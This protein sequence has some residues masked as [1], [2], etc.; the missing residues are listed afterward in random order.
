ML[1]NKPY[2]VKTISDAS[3]QSE[4]IS[5]MVSVVIPVHN[6][7]SKLPMC[8]QA[9][10]QSEYSNYQI[11]VVDDGS[12][13][14]TIDVAKQYPCT[15]V[16]LQQN[17]GPS[18]ARNVGVEHAK[19]E[20]VLFIDDDVLVQPNTISN[21][22][23]IFRENQDIAAMVGNLTKK[24]GFKN[25]FSQFKNLHHRYHLCLFPNYI[26][27][28]FTSITA[29]KREIFL[30]ANGFNEK[31]NT[32][33][34]EDVEFGQRLSDQGFKILHVKNLNVM[35]F[36]HYSLETY[37]KN[38]LNRSYCHFK[39]FLINHGMKRMKNDKKVVYFPI[40]TIISFLIGPLIFLSIPFLYM[41]GDFRGLLGIVF[42]LLMF[43]YLNIGFLNYLLKNK[44][45]FF[46]FRAYMVVLL[47]S[48]IICIGSSFVLVD[49][50]LGKEHKWKII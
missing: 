13:D 32:P 21:I 45:P 5:S 30:Q 35:H 6:G 40:S 12:S 33:S 9:V 26:Q 20:F 17:S 8:L 15:L 41:I 11:V 28:C 50:A 42:L 10:L 23:S 38:T 25:Y 16:Q 39:L 22:I 43:G 1:K 3:S 2:V 27:E 47:D 49:I 4:C 44:G 14:R 36:K 29:V 31:I 7:E 34:V 18:I 19:G 48:W 24:S 37:F 46:A